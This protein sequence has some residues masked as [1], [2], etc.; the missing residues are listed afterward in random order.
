V[1][2][3]LPQLLYEKIYL[4]LA[5]PE[6]EVEAVARVHPQ[7]LVADD[8]RLEL[9]ETAERVKHNFIV[10]AVAIVQLYD[11]ALPG[12]TKFTKIFR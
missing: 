3:S 6:D 11:A 2:L 12:Y 10:E 7:P 5:D 8:V 9:D 1:K 4:V